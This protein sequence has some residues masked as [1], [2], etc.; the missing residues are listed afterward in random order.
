MTDGAVRIEEA[1]GP[2]HTGPGPQ[3]NLFGS[4]FEQPRPK[5]ARSRVALDQRLWLLRRFVAPL[6]FGEARRRLERPGT[7]VLL[8]GPPGSGRRTAAVM[9]LHDPDDP[10]TPFVELSFSPENEDSTPPEA[11]DRL[12]LDLSGI[13]EED[14]ET[15]QQQLYGHWGS[16]EQA[17]ARLVAILPSA[18]QEALLPALRQLVVGIG[19]PRE[20]AVLRRHLEGEGVR[21]TTEDLGGEE[22]ASSLGRFAM[23]DMQR[24]AGVVGRARAA[25]PAG[26]A[27]GWIRQALD[28]LSDRSAEVAQKVAERTS[29]RERALLLTAAMLAGAP[30]N[31]V[32]HHMERFLRLVEQQPDE[33]PLLER[34][35]LAAQLKDL[36]LE[37]DRGRV[38]FVSL[39]YDGAVRRHFWTYLPWLKEY[40]GRWVADVVED[41]HPELVVQDRRQLVERFT[42]QSLRVADWTTL[43]RLAG[44]WAAQPRH[45]E[46]ALAVL[47]LGLYHDRYGA[48]FRTKIYEW[49]RVQQLS[50][51]FAVVLARACG[52]VVA[53]TH[54]DQAVVRLHHLARRTVWSGP[55]EVRETLYE[56]VRQ[57]RRLYLKL[58]ARF[59]EGLT[60]RDPSPADVRLFLELVGEPP[61]RRWVPANALAATWA[62]A[63]A[64]AGREQ[65][66]ATAH[67]WLSTART[68][69]EGGEWLVDVLVAG[70]AQARPDRLTAL[71]LVGREWMA[72]GSREERPG[73]AELAAR[74]WQKIDS[75]QGIEPA[76][77]L[78]TE[79]RTR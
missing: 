24:F 50:P 34:A 69:P 12:L 63:L 13:A 6:G 17:G 3:Y 42:E 11:G 39:A 57:D 21:L 53:G 18:G 37:I 55:R 74:L 32:F 59:R 23:R 65:W 48:G 28:A 20:M 14:Y 30:V 33:R 38:R 26:P 10:A 9:L 52:E 46:E 68:G 2:T 77:A 40:L 1:R 67:G 71:Y 15:A 51:A 54:P 29:G 25:D 47:R 58:L 43:H 73:R 64:V 76:S 41:P 19:R 60:A 35:D 70:A 66:A 49:A 78:R 56:L 4:G 72:D 62:R 79:E 5:V 16:V 44:E 36:P 45:A 27:S 22:L 7:T 61:Q 75:A 31:A 8:A